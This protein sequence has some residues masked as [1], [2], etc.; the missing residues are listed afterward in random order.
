MIDVELIAA[1]VPWLN[2]DDVTVSRASVSAGDR[3]DGD[4]RHPAFVGLV[5][6]R[7]QQDGTA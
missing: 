5:R 2:A 7:C 4:L 1:S 3:G 6:R